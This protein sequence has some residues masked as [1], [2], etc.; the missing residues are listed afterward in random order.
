MDV[1][2]QMPPVILLAAG[3]SSRLGSPKGLFEFRG[4]PWLAWQ[5]DELHGAG[6]RKVH[7]VLGHFREIYLEAKPWRKSPLQ[8]EIVIN[9]RPERGQF[10]SFHAAIPNL[11]GKTAA[12]LLPIDVPCPKAAVWRALQETMKSSPTQVDV[13]IPSLAGTRGHP[14]LLSSRF[15]EEMERVDPESD[16]ARLDL[17]IRKLSPG[18]A[19][20]VVVEDARI[21]MNMNTAADWE[22]LPAIF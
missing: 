9:S 12:F 15:L 5:L 16:L 20:E 22:A 14:V 1:H 4:K 8:P 11:F 10:S 7:L 18:S 17:Q 2:R 21:K 13:C 6:I 19:R 3:K